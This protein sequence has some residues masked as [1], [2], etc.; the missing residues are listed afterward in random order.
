METTRRPG[1]TLRRRLTVALI[2]FAAVVTGTT[3][4]ASRAVPNVGAMKESAQTTVGTDRAFL[5]GIHRAGI[6]A[7]DQQ[8]ISTAN[9][10][11]RMD[12][13]GASGEDIGRVISNFGIYDN[14]IDAFAAAAIAAYGQYGQDSSFL[15]GIHRAGIIA[16]DQQAISTANEVARMDSS[17]ASGEDIDRVISNFGV[18]G[19]H[20]DAFAAAAIAAYEL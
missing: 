9:E 18:Y 2:I 19:N 7:P 15:Q 12:S 10:V 11:A 17:G 14:H 16:P 6:I 20:L 13:S 1:A 5:Q 3:V 8:A 4:A